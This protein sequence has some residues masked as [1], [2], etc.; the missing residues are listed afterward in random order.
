MQPRTFNLDPQR[1]RQCISSRA[2]RRG[3]DIEIDGVGRCE[4]ENF[5]GALHEH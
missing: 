4:G 2:D 1:R 3:R 5:E